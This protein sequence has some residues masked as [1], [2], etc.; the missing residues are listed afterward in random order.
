LGRQANNLPIPWTCIPENLRQALKE[1]NV[2]EGVSALADLVRDRE[3]TTLQINWPADVQRVFGDKIYEDM[4]LIQAWSTL[5]KS[6]IVGILSTVRNRILNFALEIE[7]DNPEAG[8]AAPDTKPIAEERVSQIFNTNIYGNVASI[9]S[10]QHI[11]QTTQQ[12]VNRGDFAS[13][14]KFLKELGFSD[15]DVGDLHEALGA[16]PSPPETGL[17][18]KVAS[19]LGKAVEKVAAGGMKISTAVASNVLAEAIKNYYGF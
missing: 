2:R 4:L 17:G 1:V 13:L 10:G 12:N 7:A 19:W 15:Q 3:S 14:A 18:T 5:P 8:E 6:S 11:S 16:E 9:A